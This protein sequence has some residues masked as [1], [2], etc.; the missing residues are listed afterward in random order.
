MMRPGRKNAEMAT[1]APDSKSPDTNEHRVTEEARATPLPI[2]VNPHAK[3][4]RRKRCE[5][6]PPKYLFISGRIRQGPTFKF[7]ARPREVV[8]IEVEN[9]I[10]NSI[11]SVLDS[12]Y[13]VKMI[14]F[15]V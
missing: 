13:Q 11:E 4:M 8:M 7:L 2:N 9:A 10:K 15:P 14:S 12:S 3:K 6:S 5:R 1:A